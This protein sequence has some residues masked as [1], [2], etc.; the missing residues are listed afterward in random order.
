MT[1]RV[2]F[3]RYCDKKG[4]LCHG[5]TSQSVF[6]QVLRQER[7]IILSPITYSILIHISDQGYINYRGLLCEDKIRKKCVYEN[8]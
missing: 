1:S 6:K 4:K 3:S 2:Y 5:V 7:K 8:E